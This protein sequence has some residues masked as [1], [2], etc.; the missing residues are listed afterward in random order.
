L[1]LVSW[2]FGTL[3]QAWFLLH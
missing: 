2:S 1:M 3:K